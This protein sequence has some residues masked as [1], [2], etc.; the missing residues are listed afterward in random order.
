MATFTHARKIRTIALSLMAAAVFVV[1]AAAATSTW[2]LRLLLMVLSVIWMSLS[3]WLNVRAYRERSAAKLKDFAHSN[4][5]GGTV[6][7]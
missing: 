3:A 1:F 5:N 7:V 6:V 4:S 2:Q